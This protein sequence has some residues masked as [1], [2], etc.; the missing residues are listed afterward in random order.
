MFL[1]LTEPPELPLS[2]AVVLGVVG[3]AV[4]ASVIAAVCA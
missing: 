2:A 3:A 1:R 4:E